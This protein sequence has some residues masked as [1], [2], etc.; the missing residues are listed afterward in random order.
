M[1]YYLAS[2]DDNLVRIGALHGRGPDLVSLT[3]SKGT[4]C[5]GLEVLSAEELTGLC[6]FVTR[7]PY[8]ASWFVAS[9]R[10]VVIPLLESFSCLIADSCVVHGNAKS[11]LRGLLKELLWL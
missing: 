2:F 5:P 1:S 9:S 3:V 7:G 11:V 4:G 6:K 8:P 10:L